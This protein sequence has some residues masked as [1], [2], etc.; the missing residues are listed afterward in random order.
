MSTKSFATIL[1]GAA[2]ALLPAAAEAQQFLH[3]IPTNGY[4]QNTGNPFGL[5]WGPNGQS[6]MFRSRAPRR[7]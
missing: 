1:G 2:L 4:G 7:S 5:A 6:G 3:A